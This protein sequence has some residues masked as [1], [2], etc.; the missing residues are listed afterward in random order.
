MGV[1][2]TTMANEALKHLKKGDKVALLSR[3]AETLEPYKNALEER[4]GMI[5]STHV[6][7]A[8]LLSCSVQKVTLHRTST[9]AE[10]E[11]RHVPKHPQFNDSLLN[12]TFNFPIF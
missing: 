4:D 9:F 10:V 1:N 6:F 2:A 3:F 12:A 7:W 8:S 5:S 11:N